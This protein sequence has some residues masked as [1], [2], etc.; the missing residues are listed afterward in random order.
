MLLRLNIRN[1]VLI[2]SADISLKEGLCVLSGET[3][4]GKS[5]LLDSLGLVLGAR[6]DSGLVRRG[7]DSGTVTAEFDISGNEAAKTVLRE[8]ELDEADSLI[9]RRSLGADGKT[10]CLVNDAPITVAGLRRLGDT[11][12]EVHGQHDQRTLS[13]ATIHRALLDEFGGLAASRAGVAAAYRTWRDATAKLEQLNAS[14]EQAAREQDYLQHMRNELKQLAPM[15]GE[16]EELAAKRAG[17]QQRE[18]LYDVLSETIGELNHGK[19]VLGALRGATRTLTRSALTS[20]EAF[21]PILEGLEKAAIEA[22]EALYALEKMGQE[23]SFRPEQLEQV[24]ERLFALKAA[25]RKYNMPVD[26]LAALYQQVEDKLSLMDSQEQALAKLRKEVDAARAA[27]VQVAAKLSEARAKAAGKLTKAIE[28]EL[29]PLKMGGT[30]FQVRLEALGDAGWS[31]WGAD[32]VHF[33]C[34]T[35][36]TKADKDV[37]FNSLNKIAS[38]GELSRFMLAMKVALSAVRS[39]PTLIFDEIDT[40]TGGAVAAAIGDRL[41]VLGKVAQVL[42]VTHLPQV[43]ARGSQHLRV[44]K[45][46]TAKKVTTQVE[47]LSPAEREEELARMLA[48]ATVTQEARKAAQKL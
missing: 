7:Q 40:G 13:D 2:E 41:A 18:K 5:I 47:E 21:Q 6:A 48:G 44:A 17:M 23:G 12:V 24:E 35:N 25:G 33:E 9:I 14:I 34:A 32:G 3:G 31:E 11:L 29:E 30:R 27:F 38:G 42:V 28:K 15:A 19:G 46:E 16:E 20:G 22:E 10:R 39:T 36:V 8:L 4:A 37:T 45:Q 43:A 1:I 26:E